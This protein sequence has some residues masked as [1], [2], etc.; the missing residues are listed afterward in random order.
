MF[1]KAQADA[2]RDL[3]ARQGKPPHLRFPRFVFVQKRVSERA[4]ASKCRAAAINSASASRWNDAFT[5]A[6]GEPSSKLRMKAL[7][8]HPRRP[9]A[10]TATS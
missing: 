9:F 6:L 5:E 1:Q 2:R 3:A 4:S 10:A 8:H 7:L